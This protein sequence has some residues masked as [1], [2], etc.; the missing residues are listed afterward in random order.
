MAT[1]KNITVNEK[2]LIRRYL[3]WFY[4][5]TKEELERIDRKF[6]QVLVDGRVLA[7]LKKSGDKLSAQESAVYSRKVNEF[8]VYAQNKESEALKLKYQDAVR[9]EVNAEYAFLQAKFLAVQR[10]MVY[11]L[12]KKELKAIEALY[13]QEMTRRILESREHS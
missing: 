10:A 7:D 2:K 4:K 5:V 13:Q 11:F 6:T 3:V 9:R 1:L 8:K 12:G